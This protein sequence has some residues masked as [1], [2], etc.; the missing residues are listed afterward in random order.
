MRIAEFLKLSPAP[1][2]KHWA[3]AKIES[4]KGDSANE[5]DEICRAIVEKLSE[6]RDVSCADVALTAWNKGRGTLATK[7]LNH[8][9]R[10]SK[11]VPLLLSMKEYDL[12]LVKA[13]E[14]GDPNLGEFSRPCP[15]T[16]SVRSLHRP[17]LTATHALP[18]RVLQA[19]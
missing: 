9:P 13:I 14:S 6:M 7:L 4:Y 5:E 11:Q 3:Q 8:E 18:L 15:S 19:H 10:A 17:H 16:D 1:V 12:S 2:L